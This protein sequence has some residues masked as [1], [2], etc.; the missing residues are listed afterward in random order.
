MAAAVPPPFRPVRAVLLACVLAFAWAGAPARAATVT[1]AAGSLSV[2][3]QDGGDEHLTLTTTATGIHVAGAGSVGVGCLAD[4]NGELDCPAVASVTVTTGAGD[5]H[6]DLRDLQVPTTTDPG[7][8]TNDVT[9]GH[10]DDRLLIDHG[11]DQFHG[12]EGRDTISGELSPAGNGVYVTISDYAGAIVHSFG[13]VRIEPDVEE[14]VG[15]P[16]ND[17]FEVGRYSGKPLTI[18]AAGGDDYAA[19]GYG[20]G[21]FTFDGGPG[22][23]KVSYLTQSSVYIPGKLIDLTGGPGYD[24]LTGVES[25]DGTPWDDTIVS[26]DEPAGVLVGREGNDRFVVGSGARTVLGGEGRDIVDYSRRTTPVHIGFRPYDEG[27][28]PNWPPPGDHVYDDTEVIIGGSGDDVLGGDSRANEIDG[29]PGDDFIDAGAGNDVVAGGPG[30]DHLVGGDNEDTITGGA[31]D[32]LLEGGN[33]S[34]TLSG[35][36]G[37][38]SLDGGPLDDDLDGGAGPDRLTGGGGSDRADYGARDAPVSVTLDGQADDGEAGEGDNVADDVHTLAGGSAGDFLVGGTGDDILQGNGGDDVLAGGPS[39]NDRFTGGPGMDT[40]SYAAETAPVTA[41][42]GGT[43]GAHG[44]SDTIDTEAIVG[45]SGDDWLHGNGGANVLDGGPGDDHL[46]GAGGADVLRGGP[47]TDRADYSAR[48]AP[49][50]VVL[51]GAAPSGAPGEDDVLAPDVEG[52]E[53]GSGNDVLLG[54]GDPNE[55]LGGDGADTISGGGGDDAL[56]GGKGADRVD[57]GAGADAVMLVDKSGGDVVRCAR[58]DDDI[59]SADPGD[60]TTGCST[61]LG[62]RP[63]KIAR[64]AKRAYMARVPAVPAAVRRR[65][66]T[67]SADHLQGTSGRDRLEGAGSGDVL[68]G[69]AGDDILRGGRGPDRL[70]GGAGK[71]RLH[72]DTGP[73]MLDGGS[74]D[75][76][77]HGDEAGDRVL[78]RA[79]DDFLFGDTGSDVLDGGDGADVL[80]GASGDDEMTGGPGDDTLIGGFGHDHADGGSGDDV[81]DGDEA[82]DVLDGGAGDDRLDGGSASDELVGGDGNDI[83]T[84]GSSADVIDAG[85]GDDQVYANDGGLDRR[86]DCG[87]GQDRLVVDPASTSA[88]REERRRVRNGTISGCEDVVEEAPQARAASQGVVIITGD[89]GDAR[90]GTE[91]DDKLLGGAGPDLLVGGAGDDLLWGDHQPGTAAPDQ[92]RGGAG[93]DKVYGGGGPDFIDGGADGDYLQGD[94]GDD[95][96]RGGD[97]DDKIRPG[98]GTDVVDAGAGNDVVYA[99]GGGR[100]RVDCGPGRDRVMADA[101]DI[102]TGCETVSHG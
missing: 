97:G 42:L 75:D 79:G 41:T 11:N 40:T 26:G 12:N 68:R 34:D 93:R 69:F 94:A 102:V 90:T 87:P 16:S 18:H 62:A 99:I 86:I 70:F 77:L 65:T 15:T 7:A 47:G 38:D 89:G 21:G 67:A 51:G 1:D 14:L 17:W 100:D 56:V 101:T 19:L 45:G 81:L 3:A 35:G 64:G 43:G 2:T 85:P 39:G 73:D 61:V 46:D 37:A 44:E 29:G 72:G 22:Q 98:L 96:I 30:D 55:L 80:T 60:A 31:G 78:G 54:D 20:P 9:G 13:S 95:V 28:V 8:G 71:D 4:L 23:D 10:G 91:R 66:G 76:V 52:A 59:V 74:G 49:V 57:G 53:G 88:G 58:R 36:A 48:R 27:S 83:L 92:L 5:D 25:A 50:R 63:A 84:G 33:G 32:D 6:I 82:P 24:H